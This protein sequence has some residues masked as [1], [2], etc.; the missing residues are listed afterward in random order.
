MHTQVVKVVLSEYIIQWFSN[1]T[2]TGS[3]FHAQK[4][5]KEPMAITEDML[6]H[7]FDKLTGR[8][9]LKGDIR[10]EDMKVIEQVVSAGRDAVANGASTCGAC[11]K[12]V[13]GASFVRCTLCNCWRHVQCA[14]TLVD[15]PDDWWCER[16]LE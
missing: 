15:H 1:K 2:G 8:H 6:V 9:K 13:P 5:N 4:G 11:E 14:T 16:C 10:R 12:E 7:H 3:L